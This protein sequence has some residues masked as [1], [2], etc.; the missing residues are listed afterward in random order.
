MM[1]R[2]IEN[3]IVIVIV[4]ARGIGS[5]MLNGSVNENMIESGTV[6]TVSRDW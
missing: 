4:N 3:G 6:R 1:R 2:G 5:A